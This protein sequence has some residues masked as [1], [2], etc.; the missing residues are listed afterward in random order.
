[1]SGYLSG[2]W[3]PYGLFRRDNKS[4]LPSGWFIK[5]AD[6]TLLQLSANGVQVIASNGTGLPDPENVTARYALIDGGVFQRRMFAPRQ[7]TL[8]CELFGGAGLKGIHLLRQK[9]INFMSVNDDADIQ[10]IYSGYDKAVYIDCRYVSGLNLGE[11]LGYTEKVGLTFLA[12]KPLWY[13]T[14]L[15][16]QQISSSVPQTVNYI[17]QDKSLMDGGLDNVP[18]TIF[19]LGGY[20]YSFGSFTNYGR[21]YNGTW[22]NIGDK[23]RDAVLQA[24]K[25][26]NNTVYAVGN[27][28]IVEVLSEGSQIWG[29]LPISQPN[30]AVYATCVDIGGNVYIGGSFTQVSGL[31][32]S[33]IARWDGLAWSDVGG[34]VNGT[35]YGLFANGTDI[36][37]SGGFTGAGGVTG[38]DYVTMFNGSAFNLVGAASSL[39]N[40]ARC[41]WVES[42]NVYIGGD[43]TTPTP[44]ICVSKSSGWD[45]AISCSAPVTGLTGRTGYVFAVSPTG[46][47]NY[48]SVY[49]NDMDYVSEI[50]TWDDV[51]SWDTTPDN[52]TVQ[53]K[54]AI[55]LGAGGEISYGALTPLCCYSDDT[56]L[57]I[58]HATGLL[59]W[60]GAYT[61]LVTT[62]GGVYTITTNGSDV[63]FG[64]DFTNLSGNYALRLT[65]GQLY[66]I[67]NV[68]AVNGTVRSLYN[69]NGQI[70]IGGEFTQ[71]INGVMSSYFANYHNLRWYSLRYD[72]PIKTI[73]TSGDYG[74]IGGVFGVVQINL[75][76][77]Q[78]VYLSG[79][80]NVNTLSFMGSLYAGGSFTEN[81]KRW[82]GSAWVSVDGGTNGEVSQL[83]TDGSTLYIIG[84]FEQAGSEVACGGIARLINNIWVNFGT[85]INTTTHSIKA[86]LVKSPSEIYVTG[87][88]LLFSGV[89]LTIPVIKFNGSKWVE[90][91]DDYESND[92]VISCINVED[93]VT[94]LGYESVAHV[95][96]FGDIIQYNGTAKGIPQLILSGV[97]SVSSFR[98]TTTD[99]YIGFSDLSLA[100]GDVVTLDLDP[101]NMSFTRLNYGITLTDIIGKISFD[102][103]PSSMR[104]KPGANSIRVIADGTITAVIKWRNYHWSIDGVSQ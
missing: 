20:T 79:L 32:V 31:T 88:F 66:P 53:E 19:D 16:S 41:I 45:L 85:G 5:G 57:Y 63:Y 99:A 64:G 94:T 22:S 90:H 68:T 9:L 97:G 38:A 83:A 60:D 96:F 102:S 15:Y 84:D 73:V 62:N 55:L 14:L 34:G 76:T 2:I 4:V 17:S 1:M 13:E 71:L 36:Y 50:N 92:S 23:P 37:I 30:G 67:G 77:A 21:K 35:V 82:N 74:Y 47:F 7:F 75:S 87:D 6:G 33:N 58:G 59:K 28:K 95:T 44:Y 72:N 69:N 78:S 46:T 101:S 103:A 89:T 93:N 70:L 43:F 27:S 65:A 86:I 3:R 98:N 10:V 24:V 8:I 100:A 91:L 25:D 51:G 49:R 26:N 40:T 52:V 48:F 39:N 54:V 42:N 104:L 11:R 18:K 81:V 61:P 12:V 29:Y 56:T 80:T